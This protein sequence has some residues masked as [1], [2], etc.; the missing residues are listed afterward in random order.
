M[1]PALAPTPQQANFG[2]HQRQIRHGGGQQ[3]LAEGFAS[4]DVAGL[5]DAELHQPR[6]PMLGDLPQLPVR[7]EGRTAL[8]GARLLEHGLLRVQ[9]HQPPAPRP[10]ADTRG[11]PWAGSADGGIENRKARKGVPGAP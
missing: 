9:H 1:R 4:S 6:Q 3:Q 2:C 7:G 8:E 10:G 11:A 5:A